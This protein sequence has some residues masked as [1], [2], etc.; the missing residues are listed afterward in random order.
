MRWK[1]AQHG[2]SRRAA[3]LLAGPGVS[4]EKK[5]SLFKRMWYH[6][7]FNGFEMISSWC[8]GRGIACRCLRDSFELFPFRTNEQEF[9]PLSLDWLSREILPHPHDPGSTFLSNSP[10]NLKLQKKSYTI[11]SC[12]DTQGIRQRGVAIAHLHH[13]ISHLS[14]G[15]PGQRNTGVLSNRATAGAAL[16]AAHAQI[17][18]KN[19]LA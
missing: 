2:R 8:Q 4:P 19:G 1:R 6:H 5:S 11:H 14:L 3:A 15:S 18:G 10:T 9:R 16:V 13:R 7:H 12:I 17:P